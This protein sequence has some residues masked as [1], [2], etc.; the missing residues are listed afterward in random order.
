MNFVIVF[1]LVAFL[2]VGF[3]VFL[4]IGRQHYEENE[5]DDVPDG[6]DIREQ[7]D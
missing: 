2:V 7:D 1:A 3:I 5:R 4:L 6:E